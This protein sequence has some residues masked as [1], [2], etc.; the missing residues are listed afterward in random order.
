MQFIPLTDADIGNLEIRLKNNL[1]RLRPN[2]VAL[3]DGFEYHDRVLDSALGSYDGQVYQRM[4]DAAKKSP[5]NSEPVNKSFHM[6]L[7]P[8][9]KGKL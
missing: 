1:E 4:F 9:L 3:V 2:I 5:L 7:K 6:Y 8:L